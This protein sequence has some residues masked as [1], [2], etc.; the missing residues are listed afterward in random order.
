MRLSTPSP[1]NT[2]SKWLF[3]NKS[4]HTFFVADDDVW[5]VV[6]IEIAGGD[7]ASDAGVVVD[8]VRDEFDGSIFMAGGA[9][10]V[11]HGGVVRA[12]VSAVVGVESFAGDD[13]LDAVAIDIDAGHGVGLAEA[14]S[15]GVSLGFVGHD[16]VLFKTDFSILF[17]LFIPRESVAVSVEGGDEIVIAI[18]IDVIGEHLGSSF[19]GGEGE[20]VKGPVGLLIPVRGLLP[21]AVFF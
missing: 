9:E 13:V 19:F 15:V 10:P 6:A 1:S 5:F 12:W 18:A 2:I 16:A 20:G 14:D 4:E 21:P 8:Q 17:D 11:D 7:L 3:L